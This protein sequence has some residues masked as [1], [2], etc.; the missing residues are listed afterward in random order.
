VNCSGSV[1]CVAVG[2][3][4]TIVATGDGATWGAQASGTA[5]NLNGVRCASAT[6]CF[7]VGDG[8]TILRRG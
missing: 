4:G 7:A 3:G 5:N 8:G 6:V 1:V 2:A